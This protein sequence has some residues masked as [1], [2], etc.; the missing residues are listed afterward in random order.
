MVSVALYCL[1]RIVL[2]HSNI[3]FLFFLGDRL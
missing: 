2:Q 1:L 3:I